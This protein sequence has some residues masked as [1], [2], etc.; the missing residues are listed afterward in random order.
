MGSEMVCSMASRERSIYRGVEVLRG[1]VGVDMGAAVPARYG[2]RR[3]RRAV[4]RVQAKLM[5]ATAR[6][7]GVWMAR[8]SSVS[9]AAS[10]GSCS[11]SPAAAVQGLVER[12]SGGVEVALRCSR[13]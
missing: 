5:A 8:I 7:G 1:R 13:R 11:S 6:S 9:A 2:A 4:Q 12:V 10:T 3:W